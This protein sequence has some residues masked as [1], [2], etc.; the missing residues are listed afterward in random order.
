MAALHYHENLKENGCV[1]L[2]IALMHFSPLPNSCSPVHYC[3]VPVCIWSDLTEL[4]LGP[5]KDHV[6]VGHVEKEELH[7][8]GRGGVLPWLKHTAAF[9]QNNFLLIHKIQKKKKNKTNKI[10]LMPSVMTQ[11]IFKKPNFSNDENYKVTSGNLKVNASC[12]WSQY[13]L[14]KKSIKCIM[15]QTKE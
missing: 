15:H 13:K 9:S 3:A 8:D 5:R 4:W 10:S 11:P 14:S 6:V 7:V 2:W 12:Y 1:L